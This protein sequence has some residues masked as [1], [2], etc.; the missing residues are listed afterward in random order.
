ML[1]LFALAGFEVLTAAFMK[2]SIIWYV[3]LYS[4]LKVNQLFGGIYASH[5]QDKRVSLFF[6]AEEIGD[7]F[8]QNLG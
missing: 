6:D 8:L 2:I 7:V 5:L 1:H 3:M 4:P